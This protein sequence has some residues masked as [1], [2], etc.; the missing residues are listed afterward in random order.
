MTDV[1]QQLESMENLLS[2]S[3]R[4]K[5]ARNLMCH[6]LMQ[7]NLIDKLYERLEA[8]EARE[9]ELRNTF[10]TA[11]GLYNDHFTEHDEALE[12]TDNRFRV[13]VREFILRREQ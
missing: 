12:L 7:R 13:L 2:P 5:A 9:T 11:I 4:T 1:Q 8:L 3:Q 6:M 10:N